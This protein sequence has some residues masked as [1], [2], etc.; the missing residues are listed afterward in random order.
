VRDII[1][2]FEPL[3]PELQVVWYESFAT[4]GHLNRVVLNLPQSALT[5]WRS[6]AIAT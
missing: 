4:G 2:V 3:D 6:H 5:T 1:L